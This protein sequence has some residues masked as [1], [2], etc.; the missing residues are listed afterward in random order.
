[1]IRRKLKTHPPEEYDVEPR[2]YARERVRTDE[3]VNQTK[4]FLGDYFEGAYASDYKTETDKFILIAPDGFSY[5]LKIVFR[6]IFGRA[7]LRISTR[8]EDGS[9]TARLDFDI[10]YLDDETLCRL[11]SCAEKS[12]FKFVSDDGGISL[13]AE[14]FMP[15]FIEVLAGKELYIY[16][17]L[18][19]IF[20]GDNQAIKSVPDR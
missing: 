7:L 3:F 2:S 18:L 10:S 16:H 6:A 4:R 14:T 15:D 8:L 5:V 20:F 12:G 19:Y 9:F 13:V 1:M 17:S 11:R